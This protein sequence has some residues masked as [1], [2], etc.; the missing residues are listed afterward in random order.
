MC[1]RYR[2]DLAFPWPKVLIEYHSDYHSDP[3]NFRA[4]MTRRARLEADGWFV[5][6]INVNDLRDPDEL[7]ARIRTVL[8]SRVSQ[9]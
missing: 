4:D 1:F 3:D 7:I 5:M 6:L 9:G 2:A 8:A